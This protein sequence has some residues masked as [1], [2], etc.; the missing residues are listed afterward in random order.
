MV[1]FKE[2][3]QAVEYVLRA[4]VLSMRAILRLT[5]EYTA[6]D[7]REPTDIAKRLREK[8]NSIT[9]AAVHLPCLKAGGKGST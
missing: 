2:I 6:M 4:A 1:I 3:A 8:D 7:R 5:K 9:Y